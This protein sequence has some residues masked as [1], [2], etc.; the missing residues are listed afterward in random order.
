MKLNLFKKELNK[1]KLIESLINKI[2]QLEEKNKSL[3]REIN[4]IKEKQNEFERLFKL[5]IESRKNLEKIKFDSKI[6]DNLEHSQFLIKAIINRYNALN[7]GNSSSFKFILLYRAS[8]DGDNKNSFYN[9]VENKRKILSIIKTKKG[10]RF[11]C[12]FDIALKSNNGENKD[13][14]SFVFSLDNQKIYNNVGQIQLNNGSDV[15][16]LYDQPICIKNNF[17][18]NN[19]SYTGE[20]S[21]RSFSGFEKD[22]ELNNYEKNFSVNGIISS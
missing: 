14:K 4:E 3:E 15:L 12:Y 7:L 9:K 20:K 11:G 10:L 6:I 8:R 22:Y 16:N 21:L 18:S 13:D 5:E 17:L 2:N 19:E 1:D